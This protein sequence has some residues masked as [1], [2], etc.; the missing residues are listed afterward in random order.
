MTQADFEAVL[1]RTTEILTDNL[2]SSD[3]YHDQTRFEQHVRDTLRLAAH[4]LGVNVAPA[5][6]PH[7]FPDISVNGFGVEVKYTKKDTWL[8]VGNSVF[9]GMRDPDA[10]HIYLV[11]GKSGG[12]PEA[13]WSRYEDCITHVR[14]SHA[15]RFVV[16]MGEEPSLLFD[17]MQVGYEEFSQL[18]AEEKMRHIR[19]YSRGRLQDGE[20]LWWLEDTE[21]PTHALPMQVRLYM[22]LTQPEKR[23]L[24]AEAAIL[25]PQICGGSR[26]RNKYT[27]AALYL[28]TH[29]GVFCP[30]TRDLFSA[31]S[32]ALREDS[33]RGGNYILRALL[34]IEDLMRDA[35]KR[36]D[37]ELFVEYWEVDFPPPPEERITKWLQQA[38]WHA[39]G[40]QPSAHLFRG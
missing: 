25:S 39:Q 38:D 9:E 19:E 1:D 14:V 28:L 6:H 2:R 22:R 10:K 36:L 7:A 13:R 27:D 23:M 21:D 3:L 31:G 26:L 40:W 37:G 35:A 4:G 5:F 15:P 29:H 17:H 12:Q 16:E 8:A 11:F 18:G 34:D 30:Q 24:R 20:R 32:V 33:R